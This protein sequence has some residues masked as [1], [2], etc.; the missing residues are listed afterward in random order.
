LQKGIKV[1]IIALYI[2]E[3]TTITTDTSI[4]QLD[5]KVPALKPGRLVLEPGIYRVA[6]GAKLDLAKGKY[7]QVALG[8]KGQWPDPPGAALAAFAL[9]AK[10]IKALLGGT[11]EEQEV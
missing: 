10:Q 1:K 7:D 5:K 2:Y 3:P 11:G 6:A 8:D 4:E 9:D